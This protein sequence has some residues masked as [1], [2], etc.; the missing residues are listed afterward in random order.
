MTRVKQ[1]IEQYDSNENSDHGDHPK[2]E[3]R[4]PQ[5][6]LDSKIGLYTTVK[7]DSFA[8]SENVNI[9]KQSSW[10]RY[11]SRKEFYLEEPQQRDVI[12]EEPQT[13]LIKTQ[14]SIRSSLLMIS[15]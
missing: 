7:Q 1:S 5:Q 15:Q 3:L 6:R 10:T 2:F 9:H 12:F 8:K 14:K 13:A 11:P 4:G